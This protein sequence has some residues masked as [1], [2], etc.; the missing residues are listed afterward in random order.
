MGLGFYMSAF[1]TLLMYAISS[2]ERGVGWVNHMDLALC[3]NLRIFFKSL[4]FTLV[5]IKKGFGM[6]KDVSVRSKG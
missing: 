3:H 5:I 1:R 6:A 4:I 2:M